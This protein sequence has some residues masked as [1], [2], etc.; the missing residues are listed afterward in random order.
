M[1]AHTSSVSIVEPLE[2]DS[3]LAT[4]TSRLVRGR[5]SYSEED[6]YDHDVDEEEEEDEM[7][8]ANFS[9][10]KLDLTIEVPPVLNLNED[11]EGDTRK[12][13]SSSVSP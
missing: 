9:R 11:E 1:Q 8:I 5:G 4:Q 3:L 13:Y 10:R 7:R 2:T 6:G 12:S